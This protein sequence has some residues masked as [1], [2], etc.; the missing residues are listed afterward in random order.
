MRSKLNVVESAKGQDVAR[1]HQ[2]VT[3]VS[4][5][6]L[7]YVRCH[8]AFAMGGVG[9]NC[10]SRYYGLCAEAQTSA[11]MGG[12][13]GQRP[14]TSDQHRQKEGRVRRTGKSLTKQLRA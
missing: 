11:P 4:E 8:R 1:R 9:C 14:A 2:L 6:A 13:C 12:L 7:G 5:S 10:R 3:K